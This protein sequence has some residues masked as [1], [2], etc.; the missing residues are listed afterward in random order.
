MSEEER[1]AGDDVEELKE[2]R[3]LCKKLGEQ[4]SFLQ[5]QNERLAQQ[6]ERMSDLMF[7]RTK[8]K[9]PDPPS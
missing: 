1:Q 8:P 5:A 7:G 3:A 4:N 9:E 6:L 2:L